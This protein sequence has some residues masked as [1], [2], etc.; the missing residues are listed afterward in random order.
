M[1]WRL[2]KGGVLWG[3]AAFLRVLPLVRQWGRVWSPQRGWAL[4]RVG[5]S[6]GGWACIL[7][8]S[9]GPHSIPT[10]FFVALQIVIL[11]GDHL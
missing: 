7:S 10:L 8:P 4:W 5:L 3:A 1:A 6:S 2:L 11:S 9:M